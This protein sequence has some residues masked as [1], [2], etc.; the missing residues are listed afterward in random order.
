MFVTGRKRFTALSILVGAGM[1][2]AAQELSQWQDKNPYARSQNLKVG[3]AVFVRLKDGWNAE[4][5]IESTAD[6]NITVKSVPDKKI[7]PDNPSF[8]SDRSIVRKNKGKIKSQGKL[9]GSLTATVT[10]IDP[11]TGLLTV[12]GQRT[13]TYNG[14]P[15]SVSLSGRLSPEFLSR[16]NSVDADRIADLQI[17]FVGRIEPKDL[18][19]PIAMKTI[20][21]PDGSVTLKAELSDEEKQRIILEQLNRLLGESK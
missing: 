8:N 6:E 21:N 13:S 9:K 19:P 17:Q 2:L 20:T 1:A 7:I 16:D 15:S 3:T 14:E 12:Q 5:E 18:R 4:F 11:A 10:A